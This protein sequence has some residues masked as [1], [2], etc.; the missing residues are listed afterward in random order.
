MW[1]SDIDAMIFRDRN[2]PSVILWSI[3]NEVNERADSAGLR[4]AKQLA[5]ETRLMDNTR[6]VT[7]AICAF[8][9]HPGYKWDTTANA[10]ALVDVG[11]YNYMLSQYEP[12]HEKFP[13]RIMIGTESFPGAALANWDMVEKHPY[14]IGDFV[15]TAFDYMG[16]ASIGHSHL[17]SVKKMRF[18]LDWPWYNAFCGDLDL[19][20]NKKSQS[21]YR[22]VVWH[23]SAIEMMVHAPIPD[24][25]LENVSMWGWP[26]E[27]QAGHGREWKES[28]YRFVYSPVH[29]LSACC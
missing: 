12:D 3:G 13:D 17:D 7:E 24:G 6:P 15:W 4:I 25:M 23:N 27:Q 1:K 5:D 22:D 2:H 26:D 8:W 29:R 28:L 14:V 9:D 18:L 10:F 16:E 20:G 11:G 21:Y 19:T